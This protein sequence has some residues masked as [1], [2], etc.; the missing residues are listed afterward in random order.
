MRLMLLT[1][2]L[3]TTTSALTWADIGNGYLVDRVGDV[4]LLLKEY[5]AVMACGSF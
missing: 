1:W 2:S 5:G 4:L 3:S